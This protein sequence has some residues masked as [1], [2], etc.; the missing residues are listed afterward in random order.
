MPDWAGTDAVLVVELAH[1]DCAA[2]IVEVGFADRLMVTSLVE[3]V[4]VPLLIVHRN[5]FTP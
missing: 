2:V 1:D 4:Q 3:D 5:V